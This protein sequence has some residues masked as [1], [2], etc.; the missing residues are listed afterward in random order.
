MKLTLSQE[1][2]FARAEKCAKATKKLRWQVPLY[3]LILVALWLYFGRDRALAGNFILV[4]L[5]SLAGMFW[6]MYVVLSDLLDAFRDL[7]N[8]DPQ[9]LAQHYSTK[10]GNDDPESIAP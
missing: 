3:V 6:K 10:L 9:A 8:A 1:K 4:A 7:V 2:A 5:A